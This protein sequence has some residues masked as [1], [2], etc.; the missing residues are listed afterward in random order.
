[1]L[2]DIRKIYE[3]REMMKSLVKKELRSRYKASV[4][5]FFWTFL[6]PILMLIVY[7]IVFSTVMRVNIPGY[8]YSL[9]L[10][11]GLIPWIFFSTSVQQST[12][13]MIV[14]SNMLKKIYF[15]RMILPLSIVATNLVNMLLSFIIIFIVVIIFGCPI[16]FL[17][18]Y[19]PP[20]I[21][22]ELLFATGIS[23]I[24]SSIT[25]YFRDLEHIISIVLM[26]WLYVTPVLYS[27]DYI[28]KEYLALF[29]VNPMMPIIE[30]YR[31]VLMF[32]KTPDIFGLLYACSVALVLI[33]IGYYTFSRLQ[34]RF[35]EEI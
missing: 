13:V 19:L 14:N 8:N 1:M 25:V 28:P 23:L 4:L 32:S 33:V 30:A 10:F 7:S 12:M 29:Q 26:A 21:I 6:N 2:E 34:R 16:S 17:Y 22:I 20:I 24:L 5:G 18:L 31:A 35:A 27:T 11:V 3:Y 9:F 15:P